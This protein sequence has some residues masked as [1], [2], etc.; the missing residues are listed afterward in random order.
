[1]TCEGCEGLVDIIFAV[2]KTFS[3][4]MY[5]GYSRPNSA[6]TFLSAAD[7]AAWFSGREKSTNGSFAKSP[8]RRVVSAVA[9]SFSSLL[10]STSRWSSSQRPQRPQ[11]TWR[12]ALGAMFLQLH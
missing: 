12:F 5:M 8:T 7:M 2:V 9:I 1:M 3:P 11:D 4:P 10:H 6:A